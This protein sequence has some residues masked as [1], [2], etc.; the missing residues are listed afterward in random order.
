[1]PPVD[2][3]TPPNNDPGLATAPDRAGRDDCEPTW[4]CRLRLFGVI[5]KNG[6]VGLK[7]TALTW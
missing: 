5:Q 7:G 1:M 6:G 4:P 2:L 3:T